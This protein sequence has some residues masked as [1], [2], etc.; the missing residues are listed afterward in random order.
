MLTRSHGIAANT[1]TDHD[2]MT[3]EVSWPAVFNNR[4]DRYALAFVFGKM[5]KEKWQ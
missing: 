1:H 3:F 2:L 4:M 5:Y